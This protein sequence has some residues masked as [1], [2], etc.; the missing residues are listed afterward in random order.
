[1]LTSEHR[2]HALGYLPLFL[3]LACHLMHLSTHHAHGHPRDHGHWGANAEAAHSNQVKERSHDSDLR[4]QLLESGDHQVPS[5]RLKGFEFVH[6]KGV[7]GA[8]QEMS[9]RYL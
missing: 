2:V 6:E 9:D 4:L 3:L 1:M 5:A 7:L 8:R